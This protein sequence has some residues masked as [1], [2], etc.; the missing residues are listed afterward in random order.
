MATIREIV[1][2]SEH[3]PG[4][5]RFWAA[6][7]DGYAVRPYDDAEIERLAAQGLSPETDPTVAVDGPDRHCSFNRSASGRLQRT[8]CI[9]IL[10]RPTGA[11][12]S[13]DSVCLAHRFGGSTSAL[14]SCGTP[15]ATSSAWSSSASAVLVVR[16]PQPYNKER[17]STQGTRWQRTA[18]QVSVWD[19]LLP[20]HWHLL[21]LEID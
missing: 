15:R 1:F 3:P 14:R 20:E 18:A 5:A 9:W 6:V 19:I 12:R 13:S 11:E 7:L 17:A 2:D 10:Q 8:A 16:R 21:T 4:L